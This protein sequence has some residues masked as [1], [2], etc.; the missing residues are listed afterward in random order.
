MSE[1]ASTADET[2]GTRRPDLSVERLNKRYAAERRFRLYGLLAVC[3]AVGMLVVLLGSI[4]LNGYTAFWQTHIAVDVE[5]D[6]EVIAPDGSTEAETLKNANYRKLVFDAFDAHFPGVEGRETRRELHSL[7]SGAGARYVR[8]AVVNNPD[9]IGT[10]QRFWIM[11]DDKLDM[12]HKGYVD[13]DLSED[14]RLVDDQF[15]GWYNQLK[16]QGLVRSQF[17]TNFF[18]DTDSREPEQAGILSATVGSFLTLFVT[19]ILS[20]PIAVLAAVYLEEFAPKNKFTDLIEVNINNLAAVPSIVFGLLGLAV[21][22]NFFGLPRSAPLVGG[23]VLTLMTLPTIII[24][25]RSALKAVPPSIREAAL[26]VGASRIQTVTHHVLPLSLPGILTGTI[27]GM[28][29]ALGETA[30]LLMVGMVAF[31][32]D[33]PTSFTDS[34]TVLPVQVFLWSD[35]PE[36][37]FVEKTSGAIMVL[38]AFLIIMNAT[39]VMLRKRFER[40]W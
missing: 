23:I 28:A 30:P 32:V 1:L 34:A 13:L 40:R 2:V 24:S 3:A 12:L 22:I 11:A 27:I 26:G 35:S 9:L 6:P 31:I 37:A 18:T 17:N 10:T 16:E 7:V 29:Q 39:A 15:V 8:E 20:F 33:V 4:V 14:R 38:L 25:A 19:L 21:I 36:R 5:L